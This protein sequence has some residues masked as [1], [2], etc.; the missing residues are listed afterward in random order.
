MFFE[1]VIFVVVPNYKDSDFLK[2][3]YEIFQMYGEV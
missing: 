1:E 3:Y 2:N